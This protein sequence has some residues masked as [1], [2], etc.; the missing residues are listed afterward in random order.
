MNDLWKIVWQFSISTKKHKKHHYTLLFH[1]RWK[2]EMKIITTQTKILHHTPRDS[3]QI[4]SHQCV[5][6]RGVLVAPPLPSF[7]IFP[8]LS[9]LSSKI[10][11]RPGWRSGQVLLTFLLLTPIFMLLENWGGTQVIPGPKIIS[12]G[13]YNRTLII[14]PSKTCM[15]LPYWAYSIES[16]STILSQGVEE[17]TGQ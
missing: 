17:I 9:L 13:Y 15:M 2:V 14:I 10:D 4:G 7:A 11:N 1:R 12:N 3:D 6:Y 16:F 8:H 5:T